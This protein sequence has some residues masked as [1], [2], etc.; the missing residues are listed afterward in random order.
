MSV[1][2]RRNATRRLEGLFNLSRPGHGENANPELAATNGY[3]TKA[4][5]FEGQGWRRWINGSYRIGRIYINE[6][7]N[8]NGTTDLGVSITLTNI[9]DPDLAGDSCRLNFRGFEKASQW[10][11]PNAEEDYFSRSDREHF[12][13]LLDMFKAIDREYKSLEDGTYEEAVEGV[14]A[15]IK[16]LQDKMFTGSVKVECYK[17]KN[18]PETVKGPYASLDRA[19]TLDEEV[20]STLGVNEDAPF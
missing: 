3:P 9:G 11:D 19:R 16:G 18:D 20:A 12:E 5:D 8:D 10:D 6:Y 13:K 7:E 17:P 4:T 14:L 1:K 2:D 15:N